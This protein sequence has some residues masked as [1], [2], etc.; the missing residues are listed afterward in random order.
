MC[1]RFLG[2]ELES[3]RKLLGGSEA[4]VVSLRGQARKEREELVSRLL[5]DKSRW[6]DFLLSLSRLFL[7]PPL[8]YR[9]LPYMGTSF[10][11]NAPRKMVCLDAALYLLAPF[12][13]TACAVIGCSAL[14][15][16]ASY[17]FVFSM[18]R[19]N[20]SKHLALKKLALKRHTFYYYI[21]TKSLINTGSHKSA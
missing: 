6:L 16:R 4:D 17:I 1:V 3:V 12:I 8:C 14:C 19:N 13:S 20:L 10:Q 9:T 15:D 11:F 21:H 5:H 7:D 18:Q 2:A